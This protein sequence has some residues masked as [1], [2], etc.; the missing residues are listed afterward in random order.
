MSGFYRPKWERKWARV[1]RPLPVLYFER[2]IIARPGIFPT[3]RQHFIARRQ[4]PLKILSLLISG[5]KPNFSYKHGQ[6]I[7]MY[8]YERVSIRMDL[9]PIDGV[10]ID[11]A[12]DT[13]D[14]NNDR[15]TTTP[16]DY[17]PTDSY[18]ILSRLDLRGE[19]VY[20]YI[21]VCIY[22]FR[23]SSKRFSRKPTWTV[24]GGWRRVGEGWKGGRKSSGTERNNKRLNW[25]ATSGCSSTS[26]PRGNSKQWL[27]ATS[28]IR[29]S[30][31]RAVRLIGA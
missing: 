13:K 28:K 1:P 4:T 24:G 3:F 5:E 21:C 30:M 22:V 6:I 9:R 17:Q 7:Q 2:A 8:G 25:T 29:Y 10:M 23:S 12:G 20:V 18:R 15:A 14:A 31:R 11:W 26:C 27:N 16:Y 19:C